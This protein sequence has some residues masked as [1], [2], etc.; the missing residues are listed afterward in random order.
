VP[1]VERHTYRLVTR[2]AGGVVCAHC[3]R[4][5]VAGDPYALTPEAV[6]PDGFSVELVACVYC[7]TRAA[8]S[9]T[10]VRRNRGHR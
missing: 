3:G 8:E 9:A 5:L 2:A 1:A 7:E 6:R 10:R 4:D